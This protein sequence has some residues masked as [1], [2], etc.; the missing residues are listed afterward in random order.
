VFTGM[1]RVLHTADLH[2]GRTFASWGARIAEV[3]QADLRRTLDRI[4]QLSVERG[5]QLVLISG[6]LFDV[7]NPAPSLVSAVRVWLG[8]LAA[9]RIPVVIIPGNHDSYWYEQSVYRRHDFPPNT[10]VFTE[11][12]CEQPFPLRVGDADLF[13]YGIAHDHTR[14]HRPLQ[15]LKRRANQGIHLGMLHATVDPIPGMTVDDRFL[16]ISSAELVATGLDYIALGHIHRHHVYNAGTAGWASQPGS[17]EPLAIDETGPRSV[18]LLSLGDGSPRI[19]QISIGERQ[20]SRTRIDCTGLDQAEIIE[21]I[22]HWAG[23]ERIVEVRLTGTPDEIVDAEAIQSAAAAGFCYLAIV[24]RTEV[25]DAGFARAIEHEQTIRGY[26]VR[27][28]RERA[29]VAS[30]DERQIIDLA[31]KRGLVALQKQSIK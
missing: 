16:P 27:T 22:R 5:A 6:D 30:E 11:A 12:I 14:E 29:L 13:L 20:A 26:F 31:L 4:G 10:H 8:S 15:S 19:E 17:P 1:I 25:A 7:H 9:Q 18:N 21:Q 2:L 3:H 24:D 28:L 23:P